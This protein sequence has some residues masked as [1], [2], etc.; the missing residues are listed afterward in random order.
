MG[1]LDDAIESDTTRDVG[2]NRIDRILGRLA[3]HLP[4]EEQERLAQMV[5]APLEQWGHTKVA[6]IIRHVC[7]EVGVS[8]EGLNYKNVEQYRKDPNRVD[9][10]TL[11]A[12]S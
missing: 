6:G 4:A 7:D 5:N 10:P 12:V 2:G 3:E 8:H 1:V 9:V 11:R